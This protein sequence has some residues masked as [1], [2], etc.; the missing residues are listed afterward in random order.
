LFS[1][2]RKQVF[3]LHL[4]L[5][6]PRKRNNFYECEGRN[7]SKCTCR[8]LPATVVSANACKLHQ[9]V[10]LRIHNVLRS[11][12]HDGWLI[13]SY[14]ITAP[15]RSMSSSTDVFIPTARTC[16]FADAEPIEQPCVALRHEW[17]VCCECSVSKRQVIVRRM[18]TNQSSRLLLEA[19]ATTCLP[20]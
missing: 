16:P 12:S 6:V 4:T 18:Q 5:T 2:G 3:F 13:G 14:R 9:L 11:P 7:L 19:H 1:E 20:S 8:A 15:I 17:H 10:I